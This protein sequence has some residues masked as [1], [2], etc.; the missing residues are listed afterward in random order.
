MKCGPQTLLWASLYYR[1]RKH[2]AFKIEVWRLHYI[3]ATQVLPV[4][5]YCHTACTG[6]QCQESMAILQCFIYTVWIH[7]FLAVKIFAQRKRTDTHSNNL[8]SRPVVEISRNA[9]IYN[10]SLTFTW[11]CVQTIF[12]KDNHSHK[13]Q[14]FYYREE[15]HWFDCRFGWGTIKLM[16]LQADVLKLKQI[17]FK[18]RSVW[19][20]DNSTHGKIV[21]PC[22]RRT[23]AP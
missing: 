13:I 6:C 2:D 21:R 20:D 15:N 22:I 7:T 3:D 1:W 5:H 11:I 10:I 8:I 16:Q 14:L 17:K 19:N 9:Y 23:V 18:I 12:S 4:L